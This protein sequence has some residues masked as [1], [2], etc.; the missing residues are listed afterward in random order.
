MDQEQTNK[1]LDSAP[2]CLI[3]EPCL[4]HGIFEF[5]M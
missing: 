4:E 1:I 5:Q 3:F 2:L